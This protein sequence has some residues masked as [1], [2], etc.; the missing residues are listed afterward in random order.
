MFDD[1]DLYVP[2]S[3]SSSKDKKRNCCLFCK[4]LYTKIARHLETIHSNESEVKKFSLLPKKCTERL[5]II[6]TIRRKGNFQYN[7]NRNVGKGDLIVCRRPQASKNKEVKDYLPC[8]KCHGFFSKISLRQ[9]FYRCTGRNSKHAKAVTILGRAILSRIH[10]AANRKLRSVILP[11]MREDDVYRIIRYDKLI[12]L[13]GNKLA[14]KYKLQH[15]QDMIRAHLR[16][17][18]RFLLTIKESD[19]YN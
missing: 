15:Q 1:K 12:I 6:D 10:S 4:K 16:L 2:V 13:Y 19:R 17:L 5:K 9:H 3:S 8:T 18:G 11:V 7:T 14:V